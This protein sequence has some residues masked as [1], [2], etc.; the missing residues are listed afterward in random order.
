MKKESDD[1]NVLGFV[2]AKPEKSQLKQREEDRK[3]HLQT[4][5]KL[6]VEEKKFRDDSYRRMLEDQSRLWK[7]D[8]IPHYSSTF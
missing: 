3:Q 8:V 1:S 5:Y 6:Q 2:L 4:M 7:A